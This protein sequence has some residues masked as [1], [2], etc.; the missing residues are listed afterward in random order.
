MPDYHDIFWKLIL[1]RRECAIEFFQFLLK[2]KAGYLELEKLVLIQEI[3]YRKRKLL[4]DI[5]YEIPIRNSSEKLYFLLEHK[6]RKA[7]DFD[8]Q[9]IKYKKIIHKWQK[10]E[11]GKLTSIIPILFF[12]GLDDWDPERELEEERKLSNPILS[13][14]RQEILVFD[15][16]KIDPLSEF[17]S[18][19]MRAGMFLLKIIRE[20]WN[21][22]L[23][24][25]SKIR[26]I[27]NSIEDS[28]KVD[29]EEEMLD[30]IFRSRTEDNDF[31]EEAIMGRKVL[32][33]YERALEE[34]KLEGELKGKLEGKLE[35]K[36][37][38]AQKMKT[39]G[40]STSEI[41]EITGLSENQLRENGIL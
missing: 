25:W 40:F 23:I 15:L 26:E 14:N 41:Q 16:R 13:E 29:F 20:P 5:L 27:L 37:E 10:K 3:F 34:G 4:Y 21:D 24:G 11:F 32:T 6:S 33:A 39:K 28:K 38:T 2:E 30:Y 9:I 7:N 18:P 8:I 31:L 19:E 12:Q 35:T 1:S 36:L 22:F 17:Q